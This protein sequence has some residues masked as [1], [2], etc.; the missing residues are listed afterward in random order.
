MRHTGGRVD[1]WAKENRGG[2][3]NSSVYERSAPLRAAPTW[4]GSPRVNARASASRLFSPLPAFRSG[5]KYKTESVHGARWRPVL[6]Q[7]E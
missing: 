2:K 7:R 1:L 5:Y 6:A 4:N 3:D